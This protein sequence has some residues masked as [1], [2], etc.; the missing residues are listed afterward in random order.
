MSD[1]A[2][3]LGAIVDGLRF[4]IQ[5][6]PLIALVSVAVAA[7]ISGYP[8]AGRD[9]RLWSLGILAAA[10]L[11]GD[12]LRVLARAR[13]LSDSPA[14]SLAGDAPVW[15]AWATLAVWAAGSCALGYLGPAL[16]GAAVGRRVTHGTG[17]LAAAAVGSALVFAISAAVG[18]LS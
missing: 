3:A 11:A 9:R 18:A 15:A 13:D 7:A 10:W 2:A 14:M 5:F 12:G 8:R 4:A 1:L 17:W 6:N 16:T